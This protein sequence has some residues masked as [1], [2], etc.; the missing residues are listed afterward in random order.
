MFQKTAPF[1]F[2]IFLLFLSACSRQLPDLM[3]DLG[4][5]A[6]ELELNKYISLSAPEECNSF[7]AGNEVCL[8]VK[9]LTEQIWNF[10][11]TSDIL[12]YRYEN[13]EWKKYQTIWKI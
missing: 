11:I 10:N 1:L 3:P 7:Q 12:I 5:D 6:D 2:C 13:E 9:N 4:I 8:E